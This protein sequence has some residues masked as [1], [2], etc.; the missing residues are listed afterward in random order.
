MKDIFS[1][2][3]TDLLF[4][5]LFVMILHDKAPQFLSIAW[6]VNIL[7]LV[8]IALLFIYDVGLLGTK[9]E[10]Y[11]NNKDKKEN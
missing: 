7:F 9:I 8:G 5:M 2:G 10:R 11:I 3:A 6:I 1:H 4:F